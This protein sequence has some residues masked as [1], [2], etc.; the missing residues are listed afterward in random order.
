MIQSLQETI[1]GKP[2]TFSL[3][4]VKELHLNLMENDDARYYLEKVRGLSIE[5]AQKF[6]LGFDIEKQAISIPYFKRNEVVGIKYRYIKPEDE[7]KRYSSERGS[8]P[9]VFNEEGI[10]Y[11]ETF[12]HVPRLEGV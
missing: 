9:W 5:T 4:K 8:Q 2:K 11:G 10:D 1:G 7:K 3:D 12:A 6:L